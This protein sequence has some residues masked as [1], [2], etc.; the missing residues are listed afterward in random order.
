MNAAETILA[1]DFVL[2]MDAA[3]RV[4]GNGAV[5]VRD[6]RIAA[7]C[8]GTDRREAVSRGWCYFCQLGSA[9]AG[10]RIAYPRASFRIR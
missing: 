1:A 9:P 8:A 3:N 4:I 7:Q 10:S 2:T 5:L 6:D